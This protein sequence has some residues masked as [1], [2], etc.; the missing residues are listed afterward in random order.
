MGKEG[1]SIIGQGKID[2]ILSAKSGERREIFEE[3]AGISKFRHRK[4]DA[5]RKLERTEENLV[6]INDKIS[7]LELQVEPLQDQ[8]E[9]A[10]KYLLLRDEM[11]VLEI[12]VWLENLD[13]LKADARKLESDFRAAEA[14]RDMTADRLLW[15]LYTQCHAMAVFGAMEGGAARKEN[16]IALYTYAGQQAAA[17]RGGLFDFVTQLHDLLEEGRQPPIS[18]QATGSGVQIM[19]VHRSKGLEFPV[20]ILADLHKRFNAD[21]FHRPVLV[22]PQLGLGTERVDR[23]R[24]RYDTVTKSAVAAALTRESKAEE[25]RILYVALTR[26]KEKLICVDCMSHA[27][28]RAADLAVLAEMPAPPEAVA[29]AKCPGD[30]CCRCCAPRRGSPS[31]AGRRRSPRP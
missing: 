25:M 29:G 22:H 24:I 10:K 2:E 26:A 31:A 19:S 1:Y 6:R 3:A 5:E 14:A 11:R 27:R 16:L 4:E 15:K 12:S 30:C 18:T 21:D 28:K 7:E 20:V 17:G 8:A 23:Q 9:R 13:E